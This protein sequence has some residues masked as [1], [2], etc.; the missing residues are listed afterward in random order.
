M[1]NFGCTSC[2]GGLDRATSFQDAGH[3]P[4]TEKQ[5]KD[6]EKRFGWHIDE[7]QVNPMLAMENVEAGCYKCHNSSAE[8]AQA[9]ALDNGRDL[10]RI[11]GCFGCHK[12][13][14]YEGVRKVGPDLATVSGKLTKEWVRKWLADPKAFKSEARMPRFW[15]NSN[16]SGKTGGV[17]WDKRSEAEINAITEFLWSKSK[18]KTLPVANPSGNAAHGKELVETIGCYGCHSVGP[19]EANSNQSQTRRRHGF[20]LAAQG[21]KVSASW[22][23]NWV[24]DPK[25]V[26]PET[27]MPNLRLTDAEAGDITAYLMSLKNDAWTA[28]PLP[29]VDTAA[30]DSVVL[31]FLR[32]SATDAEARAKLKTMS[33]P[34]KN[35]MAGE[36]LIRRYGCFGCHNIPGMEKEQPIGTELTEA[37]SKLISQLDFGFIPIEHE[38][39]NWYQQKLTDPRSF[40]VNRVKTPEELLKMPNFTFKPEDV[41]AITMVLTSL[42]KDKVPQ[43]MREHLPAAVIAGRQLVA[44]KNCKGCHR[45]EKMGADI[46]GFLKNDQVLWPPDLNTEGFKTQPT[47]L[48]K[49]LKD[50]SMVRLRPFLDARMPTFHFTEKEVNTLTA[51]FSALDKVDYPLI[52]TWVETTPEKLRDGAQLFK[53]LQCD[54]CHPTGSSNPQKPAKEWAPNLNLTQTRLR[55]EW[56]IDWLKDP[57]AIFPGAGMPASWPDYPKSSIKDVYNG[58]GKAQVE[59]V[60]DHI[61]VTLGGGQKATSTN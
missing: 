57:Q 19:I 41:H 37:G 42:V 25:A 27:K 32:A 23:F 22:A 61:F 43:E 13:P 12:I 34:E 47:W 15:N 50:P 3:T 1:E 38:R 59:A 39:E 20:N 33:L 52:S 56:L 10:I 16:N 45:V 51:Y 54:K 29:S 17:D 26:W 14:G 58:D 28:K 30:L 11:Y 31:E 44:E 9:P 7:F 4:R 18:P 6:W 55:P 36:R 40:D 21:S 49:F 48:M 2:H 5:K 35:L 60:R 46:R 53:T 24:K 8:V